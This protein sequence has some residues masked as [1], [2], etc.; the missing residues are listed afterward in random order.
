MQEIEEEE[1]VARVGGGTSECA[2][3]TDYLKVRTSRADGAYPLA[4]PPTLPSHLPRVPYHPIPSHGIG[5]LL[6]YCVGLE[7]SR[8]RAPVKFNG[9]PELT[10]STLTRTTAQAKA[11][12]AYVW[13]PTIFRR[14]LFLS[15]P[16]IHSIPRTY[17][18]P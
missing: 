15:L 7:L 11:K 1:E 12:G 14:A 2:P 13:H 10:R 5:L 3:R 18:N 6:M 8:A 16:S 9:L 4:A 17:A